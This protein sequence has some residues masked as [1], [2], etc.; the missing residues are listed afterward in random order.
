MPRVPRSSSAS[1]A[2]FGFLASGCGPE[3]F[4][5]SFPE[6]PEEVT[7][8]ALVLQ[9]PV[10]GF[11]AG[12]ALVSSERG[13]F[14]AELPLGE[15][16][17][18]VLLAYREQDLPEEAL[19]DPDRLAGA[20]S[21]SGPEDPLIPSPFRQARAPLETDARFEL[22]DAPLDLTAPWAA[23]CRSLESA[24]SGASIHPS[25]AP[26]NCLPSARQTGCQVRVDLT[27]VCGLGTMDLRLLPADRVEVLSAAATLGTCE[28]AEARLEGELALICDRPDDPQC[29]FDFFPAS[30]RIS[31]V[32]DQLKLVEDAPETYSGND[33]LGGLALL[34]P[35]ELVV[36][37]YQRAPCVTGDQNRLVFLDRAALTVTRTTTTA[38]CVQLMK[39]D[40]LG[41]GFV[42]VTRAP[43]TAVRF[44]AGGRLLASRP[45]E[46][47]LTLEDASPYDWGWHSSESSAVVWVSTQ[48]RR[49][50]GENA[51]VELGWDDLAT[52]GSMTWSGLSNFS[53]ALTRSAFVFVDDDVDTLRYYDRVGGDEI[54][55]LPLTGASLTNRAY[56]A[57]MRLGDTDRLLLFINSP[58]DS[59]SIV[60]ESRTFR[61]LVGN[62]LTQSPRSAAPLPGH[63]SRL[64]VASG[65]RAGTA[66]LVVFDPEV[67]YFMPGRVDLGIPDVPAVTE[68]DGLDPHVFVLFR[69]ATRLVRVRAQEER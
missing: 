22:D 15:A 55:A 36:S 52:T 32:V 21:P 18:V 51:F 65:H 29:R 44:D 5:L 45:V 38:H 25:C 42:G 61:R 58:R 68:S 57:M 69:D 26:T 16:A 27:G 41:D 56:W 31:L 28:Q 17:Q 13:R 67:G 54:A 40:P 20:L 66:E 1:L 3:R 49:E 8:V 6:L 47:P 30:A 35:S 19:Q 59:F 62:E 53:V 50:R 43:V 37:V 63:G 23:S 4:V 24:M 34:S 2:L 9:D 33:R 10:G 48:D 60:E 14:E 46:Q 39:K 7:R 64:L 11:I 12:T